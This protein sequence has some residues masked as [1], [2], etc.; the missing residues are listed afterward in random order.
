MSFPGCK[1]AEPQSAAASNMPLIMHVTDG[2]AAAPADHCHTA[3][4]KRNDMCF[5]QH[6]CL[7]C[8]AASTW[9]VGCPRH[10]AVQDNA[11]QTAAKTPQQ[12]QLR[13]VQTLDPAHLDVPGGIGAPHAIPPRA[14]VSAH[15]P[16]RHQRLLESGSGGPRCILAKDCRWK[17]QAA[18][19][20]A[21]HDIT[22]QT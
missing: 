16:D 3:A 1:Q 20:E 18:R 8:A 15:P 17:R 9:S 11:V 14:L 6:R 22:G 4:N 2:V 12:A 7:R 5:P 19:H 13:T 10:L 21:L